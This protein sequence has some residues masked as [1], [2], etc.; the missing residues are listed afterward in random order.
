MDDNMDCNE[1]VEV[2]ELDENDPRVSALDEMADNASLEGQ[3]DESDY[4]EEQQ[5]AQNEPS[6]D[7]ASVVFSTHTGSVFSVDVSKN[8]QYVASG[9]EDDLAYLWQIHNGNTIMKCCGHKDSV[10]SVAFN[11][12]SS[13][14]ATADVAGNIKV[15]KLPSAVLYWSEDSNGVDQEWISWHPFANVLGAGI[16]DGVVWI[17]QVPSGRCKTYLGNNSPTLCGHLMND[18]AHAIAGYKDGTVRVWDMKNNTPMELKVSAPTVNVL[19]V[20]SLI[21]TDEEDKPTSLNPVVK[22]AAGCEDGTVTVFH[23]GNG[24]LFARLQAGFATS[25]DGSCGIEAMVFS[26]QDGQYLA[27]A[28]LSGTMAVWDIA[29][30]TAVYTMPHPASV[31]RIRWMPQSVFVVSACLDGIVRVW[32]V[33]SGQCVRDYLGHRDDILDMVLS[34]TSKAVVSASSDGTVRIFSLA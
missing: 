18:G 13:L 28:S 17:W 19:S 10:S 33:R 21:I 9:G 34:D 29:R 12:D 11:H 3:L 26:P 25:D 4:V 6:R 24:K 8:G 23:P 32:D 31:I 22:A 27:T 14:L 20:A 16:N 5:D 2:V 15:W 1:E 7:D 30:Q